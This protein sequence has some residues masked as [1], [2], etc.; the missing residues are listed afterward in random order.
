MSLSTLNPNSH[1]P[2]ACFLNGLLSQACPPPAVLLGRNKQWQLEQRQQQQLQGHQQ[3]QQR[4]QQQHQHGQ[5]QQQG[6]SHATSSQ[7]GQS[8][9]RQACKYH[10]DCRCQGAWVG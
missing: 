8:Q 1:P 7:Q 9:G 5:Q 10:A 3:Q 2:Y 4:Q 6:Q